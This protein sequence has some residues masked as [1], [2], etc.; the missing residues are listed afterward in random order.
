MCPM[1]S[2]LVRASLLTCLIP[3]MACHHERNDPGSVVAVDSAGVRIVSLS[4]RAWEGVSPVYL[5]PEPHLSIG[6]LDGP[7]D[8]ILYRVAG[9]AVL[10][11]GGI[12]VLNGGSQ[13]VRFYGPDGVLTGRQGRSGEGPGEYRQPSGLWTLPGDTVVV[14]DGRL[15]RI[16]VMSPEGTLLRDVP[17]RGRPWATQVTRC[18]LRRLPRPLPAASRRGAGLHGPAAHGVLLEAVLRKAS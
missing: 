15:L 8:R 2:L 4:M 14:W 5:A 13:E 3:G 16:T 17:V 12:A 6:A 1:R 9:G 11:K 18:A 7:D 10:Q